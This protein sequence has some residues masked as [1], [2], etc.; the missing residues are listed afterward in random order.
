MNKHIL[1]ISPITVLCTTYK[2]DHQSA[3]PLSHQSLPTI[4]ASELGQSLS[5]WVSNHPAWDSV[6]GHRTCRVRPPTSR[7]GSE[8]PLS[9]VKPHPTILHSSSCMRGLGPEDYII[10]SPLISYSAV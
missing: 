1:Q 4:L 5:G 2:L 7:V 3:L 6:A 8:R 9:A 10:F